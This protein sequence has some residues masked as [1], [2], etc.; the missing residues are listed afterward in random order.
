MKTRI[1]FLLAGTIGLSL[2]RSLSA[3]EPER[4]KEVVVT[5][6]A[7]PTA[8][9]VGP[10]PL[11]SISSSEIKRVS[12]GTVL[13]ALQATVPGF[14]GNGNVGRGQANVSG[15][16]NLGGSSVALRNLPTLVLINGRRSATSP[17]ASQGGVD[18]TDLNQIPAAAIDRIEVL[19]DGSSTIYGSDAVGGVV[20]IILKK[21]FTG[22]EI[23]SRYGF[24]TEYAKSEST[25]YAIGGY[26]NEKTSI[27]VG[28]QYYQS[29]PTKNNQ[30]PFSSSTSGSVNY[31]GILGDG[32]DNLYRLKPGLNSPVPTLA[33]GSAGLAPAP[34]GNGDLVPT[35]TG[36]SG[37]YDTVTADGVQ[38]GLNLAGKTW[39]TL[40]DE[41]KQ[42]FANAEHELYGKELKFY[43][44]FLFTDST[45]QYQ[46]NGQPFTNFDGI[47]IP[48]PNV[49]PAVINPFGQQIDN[50]SDIFVTHRFVDSPRLFTRDNTFYRI[51]SGLKGDIFE[52]YSYDFGFVYSNNQTIEKTY[53]L[54]ILDRVNAAIANGT[55][56]MFGRNTP[57]SVINSL[58]GTAFGN[59]RTNLYTIDGKF[60]GVTP[61]ELPAGPIAFAIGGEYRREAFAAKGDGLSSTDPTGF[62]GATSIRGIDVSRNINAGFAE[63]SIPLTSPDLKIPGLYSLSVTASGRFEHYSDAG[64]SGIPK[65]Q[66][67]WQPVDEQILLRGS[68]SQ[69]FVAP[70]LFSTSGPISSGFTDS[71]DALG[72][73]QAK[74]QSGSNPSL[75]PSGSESWGGGIVISPKITPGLTV[76]LDYFKVRQKDV[77]GSLGAATILTDVQNNGPAS[78]YA[79]LVALNNYPGQPGSQP[80]TSGSQINAANA[81]QLFVVDQNRNLGTAKIEGFDIGIGYELPVENVGKFI[82]GID[83]VYYLEYLQQEQSGGTFYAYDGTYTKGG[84]LESGTLPDY[85]LISKFGY[86]RGGLRYDLISTFIPSVQDIGPGG[87]AATAPQKVAEYVKFDMKV[88][89]EFGKN[90]PESGGG[91][92]MADPKKMKDTQPATT[93]AVAKRYA[94]LDGLT[95]GV[96]VNNVLDTLPPKV[97]S[98]TD[99]NTDVNTYDPIGRFVYFEASKKF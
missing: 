64:D 37:A 28:G 43:A 17:A 19:K 16:D 73:N 24:S 79:S 59:Y 86:E 90:R 38:K 76:S 80:I 2:I 4:L 46:L 8:E 60:T 49:N 75:K 12:T 30:R 56:N 74:I 9:E 39:I 44:D 23:G 33:N 54:P 25:A 97:A 70:G 41:R 13:E 91:E 55:F 5:G 94:W 85:Q 14:L 50:T 57:S 11:Q 93:D 45:N 26:S 58:V 71:L 68:Y 69:A 51:T 1:T 31:P 83:S 65:V 21:N 96:G 53:N 98:E 22:L 78:Q 82:F 32:N 42:Y 77:V 48:D 27:F 35:A 66:V 99:N 40:R 87:S 52:H 47:V 88:A 95:V 7:I 84:S 67:R 18:F 63:I 34:N 92:S 20:N 62:V 6:S 89:Y 29:D 61:F 72:G 81:N 15:G 36:I 3:Q 10:S